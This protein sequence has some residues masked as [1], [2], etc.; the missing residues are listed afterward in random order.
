MNRYVQQLRAWYAGL[1]ARIRQMLVAAV[2]TVT[3]LAVVMA[4]WMSQVPYAVLISDSHYDELLEAA[5]ALDEADIE[6]KI[7][8]NDSIEVPSS[9]LGKARAAVSTRN[10]L[11]GVNDV[12]DLRLGLTPQAQQWA[13]LRAREG[14]VARM[15]NGIDGVSASQINIVPREESLYFDEERP[16][17]ASVFLKLRPGASL[18][19]AQVQAVV[20]LV[21]SAVEGLSSDHV[22]V[23]DDRGNLLHNGEEKPGKNDPNNPNALLEYQAD[24]ERRLMRSVTSALQP[25]LGFNNGFSVTAAVELDLTS[26]ETISKQVDTTKQAVLSE[27]TE[28]ST[29]AKGNS[30]GVPGTD[31]NLPERTSAGAARDQES[32][33]SASTLNYV[34][35][36][37]DE[38]SRRPAGGIQRLSVA[39]QVDEKQLQTLLANGP[40]GR[41]LDTLKKDI[42]HAVEAAVGYDASRNDTVSVS[43]LP[44]AQQEWTQGTSAPMASMEAAESML[45]YAV[46]MLALVL[47][48]TYVIRPVMQIV[49]PAPAAKD[50]S[51]L[52]PAQLAAANGTT[53]SAIAGD[54]EEPEED[55]EGQGGEDLA[56]RLRLLVDNFERVDSGDL[57]RLIER[58]SNTAAEVIRKWN[59]N[60]R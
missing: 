9:V 32:Q 34:Y 22:T 1:E 24:M 46:A 39:V 30:G 55:E 26:K 47:V 5:A 54:E 8:G 11:P 16:A 52:D 45:P 38:I 14:D 60:G 35:P 7:V 23:A 58:E 48:F 4:T 50:V 36:T 59:L 20:N 10:P 21:S 44:F 2:L 57:N 43:F 6:Y 17:S 51:K 53:V 18:S 12:G 40:E 29:D 31:A 41:D 42:Q 19:A 56:A 49:A 13:F 15:I 27:Q 3:V 37:V 25:V 33:R 28:E